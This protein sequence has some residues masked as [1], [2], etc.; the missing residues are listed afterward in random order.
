ML[1]GG[2]G[3]DISHPC[4]SFLESDALYVWNIESYAGRLPAYSCTLGSVYSEAYL[5]S[6]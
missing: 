3:V 5:F 1:Y 2:A 6:N 4:M